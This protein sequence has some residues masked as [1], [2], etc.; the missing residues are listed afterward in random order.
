MSSLSRITLG[1][2]ITID[3]H[4]RDVTQSLVTNS[5]SSTSDF[6]WI[7]QMRYYWEGEH[8]IVKQVQTTYKCVHLA[9]PCRAR[10]PDLTRVTATATSTW[11]TRRAW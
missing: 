5:V 1:A 2:L 3:V 6:E 8:C 10:V 11:A 7:S 4:A 9:I